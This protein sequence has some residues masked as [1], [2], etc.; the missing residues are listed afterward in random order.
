MNRENGMHLLRPN[1]CWRSVTA[2]VFQDLH[3][4][5]PLTTSS[6]QLFSNC[7]PLLTNPRTLSLINHMR[8]VVSSSAMSLAVQKP[9]AFHQRYQ[10]LRE[11]PTDANN[12]V[13]A[14]P[15]VATC[16]LEPSIHRMRDSNM[17]FRSDVLR[18]CPINLAN[19]LTSNNLPALIDHICA[20]VVPIIGTV[21]SHLHMVWERSWEMSM[22][23]IVDC[24]GCV[25]G[26]RANMLSML[27]PRALDGV[28][29]PIN[30]R[31]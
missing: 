17:F 18:S 5:F 28:S 19:S 23:I 21:P 22:I 31:A 3:L 8:V 20:F 29:C 12:P 16:M 14:K 11:E 2:D 24:N 1:T 13:S 9:S 6:C 15:A 4:L 7:P 26:R 10:T 30:S 27:R 25:A